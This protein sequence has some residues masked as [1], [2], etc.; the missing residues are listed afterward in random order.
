VLRDDLGFEAVRQAVK[1]PLKGLAA[2]PYYGCMLLRPASLGLDDPERP[3]VLSALLRA[4]GAEP[5]ESP[6]ANECCGSYQAVA[7]PDVAAQYAARVLGAASRRGARVLVASCP[8]CVFN[9]NDRQAQARSVDPTLPAVPVL[10]FPQLLG[11]ALGLPA[12]ELGLDGLA[13]DPRP[14]LKAAGIEA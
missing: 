11:L 8:L 7:E 5:V 1:R 10:Y 13:V 4:I 14:A 9:L 12:S 3:V 2:S 6:L